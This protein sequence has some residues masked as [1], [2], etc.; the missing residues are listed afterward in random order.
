MIQTS[1]E[2]LREECAVRKLI[3][4]Y[5][6][7]MYVVK[8]ALSE[9][10]VSPRKHRYFLRK[11]IRENV[12]TRYPGVSMGRCEE[13]ARDMLPGVIEERREYV[14]QLAAGE[15]ASFRQ[16]LALAVPVA[17]DGACLSVELKGVD[18]KDRRRLAAM[19]AEDVDWLKELPE[20]SFKI[21]APEVCEAIRR[22][23]GDGVSDI[24]VQYAKGIEF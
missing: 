12:R 22:S 8:G 14:A 1:E 11:H 24:P 19:V 13:L 18:D 15:V 6:K 2:A 5:M 16:G 23:R 21:P 9:P 3:Y 10:F 4:V 7:E 17:D 20:C